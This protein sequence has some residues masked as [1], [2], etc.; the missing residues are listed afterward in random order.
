MRSPILMRNHFSRLYVFGEAEGKQL[1]FFL[2][3]FNA[4]PHQAFHRINGALGS[5]DQILSR[6]VPNDDLILVVEG[7]HGGNEV[8]PIFS[9]NHDGRVALHV[10]DERVRGAKIDADDVISSHV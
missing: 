5:F 2:D 8:Q 9:W 6:G 7:H 1:Q 10:S 3:V 4:A